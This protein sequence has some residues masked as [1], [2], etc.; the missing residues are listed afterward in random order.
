MHHH[1]KC[2]LHYSREKELEKSR[3]AKKKEGGEVVDLINTTQ[4][5]SFHF[6]GDQDSSANLPIVEEQSNMSINDS[7]DGK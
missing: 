2:K 6:G 4:V 3:M 7:K 5:L 1:C